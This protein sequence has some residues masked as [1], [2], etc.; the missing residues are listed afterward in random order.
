MHSRPCIT[1]QL[2]KCSMHVINVE[3]IFPN[4]MVLINVDQ[5]LLYN[6]INAY[7]ATL[8]KYPAK[9]YIIEVN[10]NFS[11]DLCVQIA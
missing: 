11:S 10:L 5:C 8:I 7:I 6:Q 1:A 2:I 4:T 9:N 3:N